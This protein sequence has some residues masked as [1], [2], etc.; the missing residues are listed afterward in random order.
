MDIDK[1]RITGDRRSDKDRRSGVDKRSEEENA[2]S[3]RGG[4]TSTADQ[5]WI[6]GPRL[7]TPRNATSES[8]HPRVR[9]TQATQKYQ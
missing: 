6:D 8:D 1:R 5:V 7:P 9:A 3:A 4:Q 2:G